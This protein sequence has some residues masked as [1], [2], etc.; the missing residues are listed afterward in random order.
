MKVEDWFGRWFERHAERHP[1]A[2]WPRP[3]EA[4]EFWRGW[5]GNFARHGMTEDVADEASRR[6]MADPP[7]FL[8]EHVPALLNEAK[9]IWREQAERGAGRD[10]NSREAALDASRGCPEC[11]GCGQTSRRFAAESLSG[12]V[13]S[14]GLTCVCP[15]GR[16]LAAARQKSEDRSWRDGLN[17]AEHPELWNPE[18]DYPNWP[19]KPVHSHPIRAIR[20]ASGQVIPLGRPLTIDES[21]NENV[22]ESVS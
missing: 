2:D 11:G 20:T 4:R 8:G 21:I 18:I 16:W 19:A 12:G 1:R 9:A 6:L 13:V 14:L 17:L 15:Y 7:K 10:P 5:I 3:S 22:Y